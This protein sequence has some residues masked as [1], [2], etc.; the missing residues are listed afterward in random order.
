MRYLA[1]LVIVLL[2]SAA[3]CQPVKPRERLISHFQ[4]EGVSRLAALA[5]V[6]ALTNTTLLVEAGS[7]AFLQAPVVMTV[8]DTTVAIVIHEILRGLDSYKL[9]DEGALLI[10]STSGRLN[11]TLNL[12]LGTFTF[13][14]HSISDLQP[15]MAY[16]VRRATGCNPQG[17]G[18]AGPPMDLDIPP[19]QLARATLEQIIARV[20]DAPEASM[21]IVGPEP[22][23]RGCIDNPTSRWQVGLY[24]YGFGRAL[25]G[26]GTPFRETVGPPLL[27]RQDAKTDCAGF[28]F[29]NPVPILLP[30]PPQNLTSH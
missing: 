28:Q 20:A 4:V 9:R 21:W 6:G 10:L 25:T 14:G 15:L 5:K 2:T 30:T 29:P 26:C 17:F 23:S 7:L 11:R 13:T 24:G 12:P 1:W 22:S 3:S 8:D 16:F 18:W 19:I 27:P